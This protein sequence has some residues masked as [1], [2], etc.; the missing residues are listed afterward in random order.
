M[1]EFTKL[2][3]IDTLNERYNAVFNIESRWV[4]HKDTDMVKYDPN[5]NWNPKLY[6]ENAF[7]D[8]KETIRYS[9]S[10]NLDNSLTITEYREAKG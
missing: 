8:P 4:E 1:V 7:I 9:I 5:K 2:G 6:I 3:D 10:R